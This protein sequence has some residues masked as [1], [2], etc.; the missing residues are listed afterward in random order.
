MFAKIQHPCKRSAKNRVPRAKTLILSQVTEPGMMTGILPTSIYRTAIILHACRQVHLSA[1]SLKLFWNK[2]ARFSAVFRNSSALLPAFTHAS[3]GRRMWLG[4][5]LTPF[6]GTFKPKMGISSHSVSGSD[7][8][9]PSWMAS[10]S[11]LVYFRLQRSPTPYGPPTQP[12]FTRYAEAPTLSSLAANISAYT[13]GC[14]TRNGAPKQAE[15]VA[16]GSV[17][18]SSVPATFAV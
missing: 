8:R 7:A 1:N 15:N 11:C 2:P 18:P 10:M 3:S 9:V 13:Y 17:T 14:Q 6:F 16:W 4:T 5:S 12:V